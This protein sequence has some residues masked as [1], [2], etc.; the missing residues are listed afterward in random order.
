MKSNVACQ[1]Y[2]V[3]SERIY[4][5]LKSDISGFERYSAWKNPTRVAFLICK[6]KTINFFLLA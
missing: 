6:G 2:L 4:L 1:Q 3:N 5:F